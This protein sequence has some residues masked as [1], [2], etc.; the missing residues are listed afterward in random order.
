MSSIRFPSD[1]GCAVIFL[2]N[3]GVALLRLLTFRTPLQFADMGWI[4]TP[5]LVT[6]FAAINATFLTAQQTLELR[7]GK[8][9]NVATQPAQRARATSEPFVNYELDKIE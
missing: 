3:L 2:D 1:C 6:I 8:W 7:D 5:L 4:R 9:Q